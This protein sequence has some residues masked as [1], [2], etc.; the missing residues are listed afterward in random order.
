MTSPLLRAE[1]PRDATL[2][3]VDIGWIDR[4]ADLTL[5]LH[6]DR[7]AL[8][9]GFGVTSDPT[10]KE[11]PWGPRNSVNEVR[12]SHAD[13]PVL[14]HGRRSRDA[15]RGP[16]HGCRCQVRPAGSSAMAGRATN[17]DAAAGARRNAGSS[18]I[19]TPQTIWSGLIRIFVTP[20]GRPEPAR[21]GGIRNH[22]RRQSTE[23]SSCRED[24]PSRARS[25][26]SILR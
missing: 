25:R 10:T 5:R 24:V 9:T 17:G 15:E 2:L 20:S 22:A 18:A 1:S 12:W 11:S 21:R 23:R 3:R 7:V 19:Q 16:D 6:G 4:R 26:R 13:G 14:L 8:L